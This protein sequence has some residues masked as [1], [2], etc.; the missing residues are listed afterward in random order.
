ML[1]LLIAAQ[2]FSGE[3]S[4]GC[5]T[6]VVGG[7]WAGVYAAWRLT[8]DAKSVPA[9]EL[10]LFE[11][12]SAVGGRTYSVSVDSGD[13]ALIIDVGAYRFGRDQHLPG[14]LITKRLNISVACYQPDCA[15]EPL[16]KQ[17]LYKVVDAEGRNAGYV[18]PIRAMLTELVAAGVRVFYKYELTGVYRTGTYASTGAGLSLHFAGGAVASAS[19]VLLNL[20]RAALHRLDPASAVFPP[21]NT[22]LAYSVLR[23]CI[24][25]NGGDL[26]TEERIGLKVYAVYD[27][28][29]W[30]SKL[31]M[32]EGTFK[33]IED[34]LPP[35]V[36]RYHDGPVLRRGSGAPGGQFGPGALEVVYTYSVATPQVAWYLPFAPR[37]ADDPLVVTTDPALLAP[38]HARLMAYHAHAFAAR[39]LKT[40][41]VPPMSKAVLGVWT[42]D[43]LAALTNPESSRFDVMPIPFAPG[44]C[45]AEPC[46]A[47]VTPQQYVAAVD[48]PNAA[49]DASRSSLYACMPAITPYPSI[50][51]VYPP[52]RPLVHFSLTCSLTCGLNLHQDSSR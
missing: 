46:L 10:C 51:R 28:P 12:R 19:A 21:S 5:V 50:P 33:A 7:G 47:G 26:A 41:D 40:S 11:A 1:S 30:V 25:C 44:A 36:G 39:G 31:N 18:T 23:S 9:S 52:A 27:D 42:S 22:S 13:D 4:P 15:P 49:G 37:R 34:G 38:L 35:L 43:P 16:M 29:W 8:V 45:Q 20:P 6:A 32:T 3:K 48:T 14:D 24:P 17:T 2:A